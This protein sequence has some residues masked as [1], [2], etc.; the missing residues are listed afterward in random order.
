MYRRV[1]PAV[2]SRARELARERTRSE[3]YRLWAEMLDLIEAGALD[4]E[5]VATWRPEQG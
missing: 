3:F 5:D 4:I 1:T 2:R